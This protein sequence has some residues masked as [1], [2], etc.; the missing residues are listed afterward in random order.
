MKNISF[1]KKFVLILIS[2]FIGI[3][4]YL[5]A[6][7]KDDTILEKVAVVKELEKYLHGASEYSEKLR[8]KAFHFFCKE[9]VIIK[10]VVPN[11]YAKPISK[12]PRTPRVGDTT[13]II[14]K[15]IFDYQLINNKGNV[16]EQRKLISGNF[17]GKEKF[18]IKNFITSF[19]SERAVFG[20]TTLVSKERF[21]LFDYQILQY[22]KQKGHHS[23]ILKIIPKELK[24]VFFKSGEIWLDTD[25]FT[26][27]KLQVVL[28]N[29][30]KYKKLIQYAIGMNSKLHLICEVEYDQSYKGLYFPTKVSIKE[31]YIRSEHNE[32]ERSKTIFS[33]KDY[34]FFNVNT[35]VQ[36]E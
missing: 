32:W 35:D 36:Y 33:Y 7:K 21:H 3:T 34:K 11:K 30:D 26:V 4:F 19:L 13:T 10:T 25:N 20:P 8:K 23:V 28:K 17:N 18:N 15:Y 1:S 9:K 16:Q 24:N 12:R 27:R 6:Q 31:K 29:T 14:K 5:S 2:I 22:K